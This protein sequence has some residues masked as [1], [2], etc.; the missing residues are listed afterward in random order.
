MNPVRFAPIDETES[1]Q[2]SAAAQYL[3]LGISGC[4]LASVGVFFWLMLV[5]RVLEGMRRTNCDFTHLHLRVIEE[6]LADYAAANGG[7][8]PERL[9]ALVM[10]DSEGRTYL[11]AVIVP[12]DRWQVPFRYEPPRPGEGRPHIYSLGRDD[13]PGGNGDDADVHNLDFDPPRDF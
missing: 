5:P 1:P 10:P 6:A 4:A 3:V 2:P 12:K 7:R 9:E 13:M 8:Y 11:D